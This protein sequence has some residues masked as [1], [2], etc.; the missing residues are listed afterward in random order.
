MRR[1]T[2][3]RLAVMAASTTMA[4]A[5]LGTAAQGAAAASSTCW[6]PIGTQMCRTEAISANPAGHFVHIDITPKVK[7][8]VFDVD[9]GVTVDE[10]TTGW[11]GTRKTI[12]GM[13]G[14]YR[15]QAERTWFTTNI[16]WA[17]LN[18]N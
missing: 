2:G 9:T 4:A 15:I 3:R 6:I 7:Y 11:L 12:V 18:N 17:T 16:A 5:A 10:D 8:K 13:Y 1:A 14:R